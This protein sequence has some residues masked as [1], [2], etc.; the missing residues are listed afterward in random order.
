MISE[1]FDRVLPLCGW[2]KNFKFAVLLQWQ[3]LPHLPL[4]PG[5]LLLSVPVGIRKVTAKICELSVNSH[6][7]N[8]QWNIINLLDL[9]TFKHTAG[10]IHNS[11]HRKGQKESNEE[12]R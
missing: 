9:T 3:Q 2:L 12:I 8:S 11:I 6:F 1:L 4:A 5:G 7:L 10:N